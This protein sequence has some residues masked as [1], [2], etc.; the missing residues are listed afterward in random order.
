MLKLRSKESIRVEPQVVLT[1]V[2]ILGA[3]AAALFC[4]LLRVRSLRAR[5]VDKQ[6]T[7]SARDISSAGNSSSKKQTLSEEEIF[8]K[9][10]V[11]VLKRASSPAPPKIPK[12]DMSSTQALSSWLMKRAAARATD[13]ASVEARDLPPF[14]MAPSPE[15]V[16]PP[17]PVVVDEFLWSSLF[18]S[19]AREHRPEA[20]FGLI[21][22]SG[23]QTDLSVPGGLHESSELDRLIQSGRLFTGLVMSIG[24]SQI[25]ELVRSLEAFLNR[26][27]RPAD[28]VCRSTPD[29]FILLCPAHTGSEARAYLNVLSEQLWAFQL[30][31]LSASS[32]LFSI[33]GASVRREPLADAVAVANERM[34]QTRRSRKTISMPQQ[35]RRAV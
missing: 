21:H 24:V 8:A 31:S 5:K 33:G 9:P 26:A 27:L 2:A 19:P 28:F 29:R 32:N 4:D 7:S 18:D 23:P 3:A 10:R 20:G 30:D 22:G 34:S 14:E 1:I 17:H 35:Q 25:D 16:L 11:P 6:R 13:K 15:H 12:D